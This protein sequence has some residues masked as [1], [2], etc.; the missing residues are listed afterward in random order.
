MPLPPMPH[1]HLVVLRSVV[2][3]VL[4]ALIA[5]A[6]WAAAFLGGESGYRVHHQVGA[7]VTVGICVAAAVVYVVMRRSAGAVNVTL[8]VLLA[9]AA[10]AQFALG[11]VRA[12]SAHI[13]V[14]VLLG[15][16]ATALTS[17]TY[18]HTLPT[19]DAS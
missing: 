1:P 7:W 15:M 17:W 8:A 14:G 11:E 12:T 3:V 13:F 16:L 9:A 4:S 18:R 6:G 5:Q 2:T 19:A 10:A